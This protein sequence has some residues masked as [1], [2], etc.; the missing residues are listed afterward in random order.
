MIRLRVRRLFLLS[1]LGLLAVTCAAQ[2]IVSATD[3]LKA[4]IDLFNAKRYPEARESLERVVAATPRNASACHYLG[5]A[6]VARNDNAAFEEGLKW[7]AKAVELEPNNASYLG[8][9]GGASLQLAGRTSSLSAASKG[10]EAMEKALTIDP[11]FLA[12]REGLFLFYD[13][14]PWPIGSKSK[15]AAQLQ[16]I[17]KQDP[18]LATVLS[19]VSKTNAKDFPTAFKCCDEVLAKKPENYIALYQYGRTASISGQNL[20]RGLTCL[21]KCLTMDPPTPASPSHSYVWQRIGSIQE[22]LQH[23]DEARK[24]YET[25]LKLDPSNRPATDALA[26]LK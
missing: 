9:Y 25:A 20:A 3:D 21:Q 4:A 10:R 17:Q 24:A 13:R 23:S 11:K 14:A 2:P 7:L 1:G 5:R 15:A 6:I 16:E 26:K 18:D 22:Q 8:I 19:V 12:A